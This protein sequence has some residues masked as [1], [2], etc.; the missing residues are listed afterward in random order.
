VPPTIKIRYNCSIFLS[1]LC[2]SAYHIWH[3]RVPPIFCPRGC[4]KPQNVEKHSEWQMKMLFPDKFPVCVKSMVKLT[5][6][7]K[8]ER[9]EQSCSLI[10]ELKGHKWTNYFGSANLGLLK[11]NKKLILIRF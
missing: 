5:S 10:S 6:G 9:V 1:V 3:V 4:R 2:H 11:Q 7:A 8:R